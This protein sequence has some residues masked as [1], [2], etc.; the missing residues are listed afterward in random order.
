M[1][2]LRIF[3]FLVLVAYLSGCEPIRITH[4][5]EL[6]DMETSKETVQAK[7]ISREVLFIV[8][9]TKKYKAT[10][11]NYSAGVIHDFVFPT[12]HYIKQALPVI[13]SCFEKFRIEP[14]VSTIPDKDALVINANVSS[15]DVRFDCCLPLV[16]N[17]NTTL[18]FI[19]YDNDF[20]MLSLPVYSDGKG[21]LSKPGLFATMSDKDYAQ[22]AYQSIREAVKN[23]VDVIYDAINNPKKV[24]AD[25]KQIINKNPSN[26]GAYKVIANR[27]LKT[28]DYAEALAAAQML[29]QLAPKDTDGYFLLYKIYK[30][31]KKIKDAVTQLE[32]AVSLNPGN[33]ILFVHL[34]D[35]YIEQDKFDKAI[36]AL[37]RYM[38]ARPD[39]KNAAVRL[40]L[41][42]LKAGKYDDAVS[43]ANKMIDA[44][45]FYG[46]GAPIVKK[47]DSI[48]ITSVEPGGPAEKA[49]IKPGDE[50]TEI[51]GR[52]TEELKFEDV[53]KKLRGSEG[54]NVTLTIKR[55]EVEEPFKIVIERQKFYSNPALVADYMAIIAMA[56]IQKG[57]INEAK[58]AMDEALNIAKSTNVYAST[59]KAH[60]CLLMALNEYD[61]VIENYSKRNEGYLQLM[62]AIA[63]AKKGMYENAIKVYKNLN[64]K[65]L[66]ISDNTLKA[67][68]EAMKP[69]VEE[70]EKEALNYEKSGD[71]I[72]ALKIYAG[73][74]GIVSEEKA[75]SIR[76]KIARIIAKNPSI[77]EI[78]GIARE[79]F[80][81]SEVLYNA[82]RYEEALQELEMAK[83]YIPFNPQIYFSSSLVCEKLGDYSC[84][85]K[86]MEIVLQLQPNHP[87]AQTIRDQ[88]YKWKFI[89]EKEL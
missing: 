25:A 48:V 71:A 63:Y 50:I 36:N 3:L 8:D 32:H 74:L 86:N 78:S 58:R 20:I 38:E 70:M 82:G 84:A 69:Y 17:A 18:Q 66:P 34:Y 46:I 51:D 67:F 35:F 55:K 31:Q 88:I 26:T 30:A 7:K 12:G 2:L 61:R 72:S 15:M 65:D 9:D 54:T 81:K 41:L 13:S 85:I 44:L 80:L 64:K 5:I 42:Y 1:R 73:I 53:I 29:T 77:I 6:M 43:I 24:I 10:H 59:L 21:S 45:K 68:Y 37:K 14:S 40:G 11:A 16:F 28:G 57:N 39:D 89:L 56:E 79:H 75:S 83:S 52:S 19:L 76:S 49:G 4:T 22:V 87:Q 60:A 62:V 33:A 23:S 47:D 27:A